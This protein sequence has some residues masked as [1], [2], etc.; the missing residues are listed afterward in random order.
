MLG[1]DL[2][3]EYLLTSG[4][5]AD[6]ECQAQVVARTSSRY[7]GHPNR[8]GLLCSIPSEVCQTST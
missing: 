4:G 6:R 7:K 1:I 5:T 2:K 8:T 3:A